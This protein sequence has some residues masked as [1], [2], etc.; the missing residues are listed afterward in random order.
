M[1]KI[2]LVLFAAAFL[3]SATA[4]SFDKL[5]NNPISRKIDEAIEKITNRHTVLHHQTISLGPE[6]SDA[7]R[8]LIHSFEANVTESIEKARNSIDEIIKHAKLGNVDERR[9]RRYFD[10][11]EQTGNG[12]VDNLDI[13]MLLID[14]IMAL[15]EVYSASTSAQNELEA[16]KERA[17]RCSGDECVEIEQ[18]AKN[19]LTNY[20]E[21]SER[22]YDIYMAF[23][24]GSSIVQFVNKETDYLAFLYKNLHVVELTRFCVHT[25]RFS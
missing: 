3:A 18:T 12:V 19:I 14:A 8:A 22:K 24:S 11:L 23:K 5:D 2:I 25:V 21:Q 20:Y 10:D 13:T 1:T 17:N 9:C 4:T 15:S 16:L 7:N 6:P